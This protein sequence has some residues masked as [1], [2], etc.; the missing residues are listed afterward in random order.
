[1]RKRRSTRFAVIVS[2]VLCLLLAACTSGTDSGKGDPAG[3]SSEPKAETG[4]SASPTAKAS[5]MTAP[6]E[7]PIVTKKQEI[8]MYTPKISWITEWENNAATKWL[9]KKTNID[10]NFVLGPETAEEAKQKLNLMLASG[11]KLPDV[12]MKSG[13]STDQIATYGSQGLFLPL[14]DYIEK[15]G[16]N[17]K[18]LIEKYPNLLK[19]I[20]APDG[21]IYALPY[22]AECMHCMYS[23]RFWI[24]QKWLDAAGQKMPTTPDELYNVFMAFKQAKDLNGNGKQD[25]I[26]LIATID[27]WNGELTGFLM[28]PFVPS[29]GKAYGWLYM[30]NNQVKASY[31]QDGW[32]DGLKF[33]KKMYDDGLIDKE[34]FSLKASQAKVLI[35]GPDGNRVGAFA[36]GA[37]SSVIDIGVKGARDDFVVVPPLKGAS[38][39]QITPWYEPFGSPSFVITKYAANPEVAFRL[40]DALATDYS[41][42]LEWRNF[43]YGP[44][45]DT[46]VKPEQG[47]KGLNGQQALWKQTFQWGTPNDKFWA[48]T[49]ILY[50]SADDKGTLAVT[51]DGSFN[52]EQILWDAAVKDYKP[53]G[54]SIIPP[55]I[56]YKTDEA[57]AI[58]EPKTQL[59]NYVEKSI[60]EFVTG[61]KDIDKDWEAYKKDIENLGFSKYV[62]TMQKAYD[63]QYK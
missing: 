9:E 52:Q 23:Q 34:A 2:V 18:K 16:T 21:K 41:R 35:G 11:S 27:G 8:S 43:F 46:W 58:A 51:N 19:Q 62:S 37:L 20:T 12:F 13:L 44:E 10:V 45:G 50:A 30:D 1:M 24:N 36:D 28:N 39:K 5:D 53:H 7:F 63:R 32:K 60:M 26:P 40:G 14:N 56:F 22:V 29:N 3:K 31:M 59:T 54:A 42:D 25:E 4:N 38:G 6:G 17:Y 47:V 55:P 33:L 49:G 61:K 57:E 15:Y 48:T